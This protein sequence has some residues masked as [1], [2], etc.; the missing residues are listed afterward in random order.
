MQWDE[1]AL[2][3]PSLINNTFNVA[4]LIKKLLVNPNAHKELSIV[5]IQPIRI[6][7]VRKSLEL[8]NQ[9]C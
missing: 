8:S 2:S 9:N 5:S 6:T 3:F 4:I 1:N 7:A